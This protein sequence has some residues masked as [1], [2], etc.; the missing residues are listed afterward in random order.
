VLGVVV[1]CGCGYV[2][3]IGYLFCASLPFLSLPL[4]CLLASLV[5]LPHLRFS[6]AIYSLTN[7][8][9][10]WEMG[11]GN[12]FNRI[13][14]PLLPAFRVVFRFFCIGAS[15]H[16]RVFALA[17]SCFFTVRVHIGS[18]RHDDTKTPVCSPSS[19]RAWTLAHGNTFM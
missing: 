8:N 11:N 18:C 12:R 7:T 19:H 6:E 4:G 15:V 13:D 5:C 1:G 9:G 17:K 2:V 10:K 16:F 14:A 3:H